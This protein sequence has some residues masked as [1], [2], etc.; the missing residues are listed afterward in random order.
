MY[1]PWLGNHQS[2]KQGRN[3]VTLYYSWFSALASE[4]EKEILKNTDSSHKEARK[5]VK[6][7]L[8]R[9]LIG[10]VAQ[11]WKDAGK[12]LVPQ[13]QWEKQGKQFDWRTPVSNLTL[14]WLE[15]KLAKMC[16]TPPT[17]EFVDKVRTHMIENRALSQSSGG[18]PCKKRKSGE[19]GVA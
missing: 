18:S 3:R 6:G 15:G 12:D 10:V 17:Q 5:E 4:E 16:T 11:R 13:L 7:R 14:S 19:G 8:V 2:L 9:L 1:T